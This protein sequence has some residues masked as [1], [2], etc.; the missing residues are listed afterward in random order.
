MGD[1]VRKRGCLARSGT[2]DNEKRPHLGQHQPA[3]LDSATLLRIE[4][5]QARPPPQ[6]RMAFSIERPQ[7]AE[8]ES[9]RTE[10]RLNHD[11]PFVRN[12]GSDIAGQGRIVVNHERK[13]LSLAA[14]EKTPPHKRFAISE[15]E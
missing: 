13:R 9:V 11:S 2:G 12:F 1:A 6:A 7:A 8:L 10:S 3:M 15:G 5:F 4:L 14:L